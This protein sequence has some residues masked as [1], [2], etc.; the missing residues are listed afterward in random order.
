MA[1]CRHDQP[2][3]RRAERSQTHWLAALVPAG[4]APSM[5]RLHPITINVEMMLAT[6][7]DTHA[8]R[9]TRGQENG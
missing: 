5:R 1:V 9:N 3:A 4:V 7:P 2:R 6:E 8:R